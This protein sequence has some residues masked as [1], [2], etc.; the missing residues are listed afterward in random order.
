MDYVSIPPGKLP[1]PACERI[2]ELP[3]AEQPHGALGTWLLA[4]AEQTSF[5]MRTLG[6]HQDRN[7]TVSKEDK[8]N[9]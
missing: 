9:S 1:L 6:M 2:H 3:G 4:A 5:T 7:K 8:A